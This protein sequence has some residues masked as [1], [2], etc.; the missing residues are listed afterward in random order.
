MSVL[1]QDNVLRLQVAVDDLLVVQVLQGQDSLGY[2]EV[3]LMLH[4]VVLRHDLT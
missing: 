3:A 4:L 1:V 2:I